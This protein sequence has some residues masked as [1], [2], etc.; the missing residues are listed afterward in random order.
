[1]DKKSHI[2]FK[3]V[4]SLL[5]EVAEKKEDHEAIKNLSAMIQE[6]CDRIEEIDPVDSNGTKKA[7]I[8]EEKLKILFDNMVTGFAFHR[9]ILNDKNV[10]I[11]Y[12]FI[13][14]NEAFETLTGLKAGKII[15]KKVTEVFPAMKDD[16]DDWISRYGEVA[17]TGNPI[18]FE[19]YSTELEKW[20]SVKA[21]SP[22]KG[23]FATLFDDITDQK[24]G[25][26]ELRNYASMLK[27]TL[28]S[29]TDGILV[30]DLEGRIVDYNRKFIE[31]WEFPEQYIQ[32][33][34][35]QDLVAPENRDFAMKHIIGRLRNPD[36]FISKVHD[37][38]SKP[39]DE[40][41]DILHFMNGKV[42]ERFSIPQYIEN[43]PVGRVWSF[44][45]ITKRTKAE[46]EL[47]EYRIHLEEIVKERTQELVNKNAELEHFNS[48]F[49]GR[50]LRIKEL[51][52]KL[53]ELEKKL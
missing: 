9:I 38:Y 45:D 24:K 30:V 16:P 22:M 44:R 52:D 37:L 20:Y 1:M 2:L 31:V 3:K 18:E 41:I 35:E 10:A 23:Y 39:N 32:T 53:K 8:A 28:N 42:V 21:Y 12:E 51:K 4:K 6:L 11:D 34:R 27:A 25:T 46:E 33:G 50:E 48:L 49:V 7:G 5:L 14:V 19:N 40:S 13:E 26:V 36:E 29:T 43:K 15:G 17:K 47:Y